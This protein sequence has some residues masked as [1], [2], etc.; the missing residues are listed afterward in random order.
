RR[1]S[2]RQTSNV[3]NKHRQQAQL[4]ESR[5]SRW[6]PDSSRSGKR[7]SGSL[8]FVSTTIFLRSAETLC[9]PWPFLQKSQRS[10]AGYFFPT[11]FF[12]PRPSP[13]SLLSSAA[14]E[15]RILGR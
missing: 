3:S 4:T 15:R 14:R 7:S 8:R 1:F 12:V 5:S 13:I 2:R 10:L 9:S 11:S 6:K